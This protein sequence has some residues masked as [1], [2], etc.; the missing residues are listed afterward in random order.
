MPRKAS[1]KTRKRASGKSK[2]RRGSAATAST[3]MEAERRTLLTSEN[4]EEGSTFSRW[5]RWLDTVYQSTPSGDMPDVIGELKQAELEY[6]RLMCSTVPAEADLGDEG[7]RRG[8]VRL[9]KPEPAPPKWQPTGRRRA[10]GGQGIIPPVKEAVK[11]EVP[12]VAKEAT[13]SKPKRKRGRP[14]KSEGT[15]ITAKGNAAIPPGAAR[16]STPK[17]LD[18]EDKAK[19]VRMNAS[20]SP[21]ALPTRVVYDSLGPVGIE[22]IPKIPGVVKTAT[23][24]FSHLQVKDT[25]EPP[26]KR[27]NQQQQ[28]SPATVT[29]PSGTSPT[30]SKRQPAAASKASPMTP[31]VSNLPPGVVSHA[32]SPA[33]AYAFLLQQ[34]ALQHRQPKAAPTAT[35]AVGKPSSAVAT[36]GGGAKASTAGPQ[37]QQQ[38]QQRELL[39]QQL[40]S[41]VAAHQASWGQ[42]AQ[43]HQAGKTAP[44][45]APGIGQFQSESSR[46]EVNQQG[47]AAG[48]RTHGL[49]APR[50][51]RLAGSSVSQ[52][53]VK[54]V[55][56]LDR[57]PVSLIPR[58]GKES[59]TN[60]EGEKKGSPKKERCKEAA[61]GHG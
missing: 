14:R 21:K 42:A 53:A 29:R 39:V 6:T 7:G 11:V 19:K 12:A 33:L 43:A 27:N 4:S 44:S 5:L 2:G 32:A 23:Q 25:S 46:R 17:T 45:T 10:G 58:V 50:I 31:L 26:V 55:E 37:Q 9:M 1:A 13:E 35:A 56:K 30:A 60:A 61:D 47:A 54:S 16:P 40:K 15:V 28:P 51:D 18:T 3:A 48:N 8:M 41:L 38:Q 24:T 36:S 59:G 22:A 20:S 49:L 34:A 57:A 52:S